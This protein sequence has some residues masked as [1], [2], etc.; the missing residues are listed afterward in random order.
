M[1]DATGLVDG[2]GH[3]K[4]QAVLV[5]ED[6]AKLGVHRLAAMRHGLVQVHALGHRLFGGTQQRGH[7][8]AGVG[9]ALCH[10]LG[11]V[12]RRA[13]AGHDFFGLE[14]GQRVQCGGPFFQ[15]RVAGVTRGIGFHQVAR[16]QHF[17][18]RHPHNGV[19]LG[20]AGAHVHDLDFKLAHP[21]RHLVLEHHGRPGQAGDRV[22]GVKQAWKTL[23]LAL[24]VLRTAFHNHLVS[25][26]AGNDFLHAVRLVA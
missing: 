6:L 1:F 26:L 5:D 7:K 2:A 3:V 4:R 20:V 17:L 16:E 10:T 13:A 24:H 11:G 9:Q 21:Q 8:V 23:V 12:Q 19:A 18:R 14:G 25:A 15:L 22:K